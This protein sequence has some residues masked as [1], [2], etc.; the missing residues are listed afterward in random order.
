MSRESGGGDKDALR[1]F[2][3]C[4]RAVKGLD[5]LTRD[6]LV[7]PALRLNIDLFRA[8]LIQR[9]D[10]INPSVPAP[11]NPLEILA[12]CAVTHTMQKIEHDDLEECRARTV[13][14]IEEILSNFPTEIA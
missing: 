3:P 11:S 1:R 10:S 12:A 8:Q 13:E 14:C 6:G 9:D 5:L 2:F 7:L 4:K